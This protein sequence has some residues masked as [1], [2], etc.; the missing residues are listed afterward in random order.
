MWDIDRR[1]RWG[2]MV[3]QPVGLWT[4][5]WGTEAVRPSRPENMSTNA[6]WSLKSP[7]PCGTLYSTATHA[8]ARTLGCHRY[9]ERHDRTCEHQRDRASRCTRAVAAI[10]LWKTGSLSRAVAER[11]TN[12]ATVP[13]GRPNL[14]F[15]RGST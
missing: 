2:V 10:L 4:I 9:R 7:D 3:S 15:P 8:L 5:V 11:R 14:I 6:G 13:A 12:G 1:F